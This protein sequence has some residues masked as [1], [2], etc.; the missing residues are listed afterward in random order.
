MRNVT[1]LYV[2]IFVSASLT[3]IKIPPLNVILMILKNSVISRRRNWPLKQALHDAVSHTFYIFHS[4][5]S[6]RGYLFKELRHTNLATTFHSRS[7]SSGHEGT[8]E[9]RRDGANE[10]HLTPSSPVLY[11][12]TLSR[13]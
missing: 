7:M 11:R 3:V 10:T 8:C 9:V 12:F 1:F 5:R 4:F 13:R 2:V 6:S